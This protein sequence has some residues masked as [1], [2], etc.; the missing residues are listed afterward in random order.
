MIGLSG[1]PRSWPGRAHHGRHAQAARTTASTT[2]DGQRP[3][4]LAAATARGRAGGPPAR[5]VE[6]RAFDAISTATCATI[7]SGVRGTM[8]P[9][10]SSPGRRA[11]R[12]PG[13]QAG[14]IAWTKSTDRCAASAKPTTRI[15]GRR[16]K[17]RRAPGR[18]SSPRPAS[19]S[20]RRPGAG[21]GL[22]DVV[23]A[24]ERHAHA[25]AFERLRLAEQAQLR[26][27]DGQR[28][29]DAR[30]RRSPLASRPP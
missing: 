4:R 14:M 12:R 1:R 17:L 7:L 28:L 24:G 18:S 11:H 6:R 20:R 22:V 30:R 8:T 10:A 3:C 25:A 5:G 26:G 2:S 23:A 9:C 29:V 19:P 27:R 16:A 21:A 15:L 13:R